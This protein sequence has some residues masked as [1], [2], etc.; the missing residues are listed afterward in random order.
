[1]PEAN[2]HVCPKGLERQCG[3]GSW[4]GARGRAAR[5]RGELGQDHQQTGDRDRPC[6]RAQPGYADEIDHGVRHAAPEEQH[7]AEQVILLQTLTS[8][9]TMMATANSTKLRV[10]F[11][12]AHGTSGPAGELR[13]VVSGARERRQT[14]L[15]HRTGDGNHRQLGGQRTRAIVSA[16]ELR[17]DGPQVVRSRRTL[18]R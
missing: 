8:F 17:R 18:R 1:M 9:A 16:Q 7:G 14:H 6:C 4:L 10:L 11:A 15:Q 2:R 12:G 3:N 5:L 13:H